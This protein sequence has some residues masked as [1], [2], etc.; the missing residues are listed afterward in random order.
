MERRRELLESKLSDFVRTNTIDRPDSH[1]HAH[2]QAV[3]QSAKEIAAEIMPPLSNRQYIWMLAVA[4]LHDVRDHKYEIL[5][6]DEDM[7]SFLLCVQ[8]VRDKKEAR[9]ALQCIDA[10]SFSAEKRRG[11]RYY[12]SILPA[13]WIAVRDIVSDADKLKAIGL[14]GV[15]RCV[16]Y[17]KETQPRLDVSGVKLA[18]MKHAEEKLLRIHG[19]FIRTTPGKVLSAPLHRSMSFWLGVDP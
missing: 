15:T 9:I 5:L 1:G 6:T 2:M 10:I 18:V 17:V 16:E 11:M 12:E 8:A 7:M 3:A 13:E 4:W 19:Q 14:H